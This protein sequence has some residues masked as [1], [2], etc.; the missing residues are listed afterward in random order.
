MSA[1]EAVK[2][3]VAISG[4]QTGPAEDSHSSHLIDVARPSATAVA[5][6]AAP[7][8]AGPGV[9]AWQVIPVRPRLDAE[10]HPEL[11]EQIH[12]ALAEGCGRIALDLT[13]NQFFSLAA[14]QLCVGLARDLAGENGQLALVG[15]NERT[16]KHFDVYASLKQITVV[17]T[18]S[19]L[20]S[21]RHSS[22]VIRGRSSQESR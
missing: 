22:V 9:D 10:S 1:I 21:D 6:L 5:T 8:F 20:L 2:D 11:M 3:R 12:E 14:I 13:Q 18:L 4:N 17:R 7:V 16:K 19:E 15:C